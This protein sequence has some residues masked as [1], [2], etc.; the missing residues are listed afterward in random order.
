MAVDRKELTVQVGPRM[1]FDEREMMMLYLLRHPGI[2]LEAK[3]LLSPDLFTEPYEIVWAVS[4]RSAIDLY[5]QFGE[6]PGLAVLE[7]DAL[8]R[9]EALPDG[10]PPS[11]ID[12]MR[13]F[14]AAIFGTDDSVLNGAYENYGYELLK[15]FL[16]ERFLAD[17]VRSQLQGSG[18]AVPVN[19]PSLFQD[20]N[21]RIMQVGGVQVSV[22]D[23]L[24][25]DQWEPTGVVRNSTC[26]DFFD[27]PMGG[28]WFDEEVYGILGPFGAG[29]TMLACQLAGE[30]ASSFVEQS[31]KTGKPHRHTFFFTYEMS[32]DEIRRRIIAHLAGVNL[33]HLAN[34][35]WTSSLTRT[36]RRHPYEEEL[37]S[38][39]PFGE[40]E[41]VEAVRSISDTFH[42]ADM[43]GS[44]RAPKAGSG[45]VDEIHAEIEKKLRRLHHRFD[46][47]DRKS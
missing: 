13:E 34:V 35:P 36:G 18:S 24:M 19:L 7:A 17:H 11:V 21:N 14:L 31:V 40:Y 47:G 16:N 32:P 15:K 20:Y 1:G 37:F 39:D 30:I 25:P 22:M 42:I 4:W 2:F 28:G 45:W 38:E 5:D 6:M 8:S 23:N 26:L 33:N 27:K 44:R 29:K 10:M 43:R 3:E 12:E 9:I 46:V 41:R